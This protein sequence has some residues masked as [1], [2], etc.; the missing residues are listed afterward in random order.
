MNG[1]IHLLSLSDDDFV[2][3]NIKDVESFIESVEPANA[4]D[5]EF[6]SPSGKGILKNRDVIL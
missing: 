4:G 3:R 6:A 2:L 5:N 1:L